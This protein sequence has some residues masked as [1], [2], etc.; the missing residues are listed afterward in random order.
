V[1]SPITRPS[2][3][4][5]MG[6]AIC[7]VIMAFVA[8]L[9]G[10]GVRPRSSSTGRIEVRPHPVVAQSP[11]E[12]KPLF[13]GKDLTGWTLAPGRGGANAATGASGGSVPAPPAWKVEN[14]VLVGGQAAPGTRTGGL[15]TVDQYKDFELELDFILAEHGTQCSAELVGPEQANASAEKSCLYNSGIN[16]RTGYQ[17]NIGRREAGEFI[18]VV[19]HRVAPAAIRR[20]VLWLDK[21]DEKFPTL[22]KKEDWNHLQISFKGPHLQVSLNGKKICDVTDDPTDV[23]EA[24]WKEAGPIGLQWPPATE[25]GGFDGYVKYRNI[26]IR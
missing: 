21:G 14:G 2:T 16:M 24:K 11:G 4:L 26:R 19:V 12:W 15:Q 9:A 3:L 6:A 7:F 8:S 18:G 17:V 22:R 1:R 23:A 5:G 13:N 20:N 10:S 25:G